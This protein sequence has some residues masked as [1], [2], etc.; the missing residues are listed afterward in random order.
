MTIDSPS[1]DREAVLHLL[2]APVF[3]GR[4]LQGLDASN[5]VRVVEALSAS[6][7]ELSVAA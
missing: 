4:A 5:F 7:Q 6:R 3:G 1:P 2:A